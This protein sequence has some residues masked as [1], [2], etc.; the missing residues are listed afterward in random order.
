[1][2]HKLATPGTGLDADL[3]LALEHPAEEFV[4][5]YQPVVDLTSGRVVA[6]ESL[7]RWRHPVLGLLAPNRFIRLAEDTGLIRA[8]GDWALEQVVRDASVL[9]QKGRDLDMAI[10]FSVH[11]LND[12]VVGKVQRALETSDVRPGRLTVEVTESAFVKDEGITAATYAA[13]STMGVKFAI[14][15][16]GT[17]FSSLLRLRLYPINALKIDRAVVAGIGQSADDEAICDSIISL[18]RAVNASTVA[19]GVETTEQ[20][21]VLRS[22]GC[23]RGQGWLWSPAVP[24]DQLEDA[25]AACERV[26]VAERQSRMPRVS[27]GVSSDDASLIAEMHAAGSSTQDIAA[28]LNRTVGRHP[29]GVRWTAG[30][31]ARGLPVSAPEPLPGE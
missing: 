25:I 9:T 22:M 7:V 21:A 30:A 23:Q 4:M 11:Q 12:E 26:P 20:Y 2:L 18:A 31:V 24:I 6:V 15:D 5:H 16:F 8:L 17:S 1:M 13:L 14:D 3:R 10:N 27:G 29:S 19:E 28:A